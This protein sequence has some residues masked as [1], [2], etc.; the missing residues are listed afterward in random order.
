M[1]DRQTF[2]VMPS[3]AEGTPE[4]N[5]NTR[6]LAFKHD[7]E[8]AQAHYY[9][10]TFENGI[11][12]EM[13]P[14]D[15]AA[16]FRFTFN[17]DSSNILFDNVSNKGGITLDANNGTISGYTDQ[18][19]GLSTG[20]TR[21][22]VYA[23]FDKPVKKGDT[24]TGEDRDDVTGYYQFDT[25]DDKTVN[26]KIAT[27]LISV[28]QAKKNLEQEISSEDTFETIKKKSEEKWNDLLGII[29]VEG[30]TEEQLTTLYSNMYRLFLYPNSR[31]E[32]T[33]TLEN[34]DFKYASQLSLN[35]CTT[36]TSTETC[37]DIEKGKFYVNNGFW[38]TYRASWP[39]Y[40]LLTPTK[41][42]EM[43][44][45]FVQHYKDGGWISRWSSPGYADLMTGTSANIVFSDAYLEGVT[46]FDVE[47]F[48]QSAIKD[49][50]VAPPN[51]NVGRKGM[52][53]SVFNGY[54]STSTGEGLSWALEGYINDFGIANLAQA[55]SKR[56]NEKD[57][58]KSY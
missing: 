11:K 27:S 46:N 41:T 45:G 14:T 54:T 34:P 56:D 28:E 1:G 44:D 22:F 55:L 17:G 31:Y 48:Y 57:P 30:A 37:A 42:G 5:R 47:S 38:D 7:N 58:Y 43:I 40:S 32:N 8:I 26:M 18:K 15:H 39:A 13:T 20:A 25:T 49:A 4:I 24:L 2:Q 52:E 53:T 21:M 35:P 6:A 19:S 50:A 36:S 29:E 12:T 51:N 23:E 10:V 33:G 16:V 3:D 9:G